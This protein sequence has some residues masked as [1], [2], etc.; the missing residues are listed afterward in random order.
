MIIIELKIQKI[1]LYILYYQ[2]VYI[3]LNMHL[4]LIINYHS[5]G[6]ILTTQPH[7]IIK[8]GVVNVSPSFYFNVRNLVIKQQSKTKEKRKNK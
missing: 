7:L 8:F 3:A 4:V 6:V 1:R 2:H 5:P